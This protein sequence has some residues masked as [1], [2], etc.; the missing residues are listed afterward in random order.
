MKHI[1]ELRV[2]LANNEI[3]VLAINESRL[4]GTISDN[5]V[6]INGYEIVRRER[7]LNGRQR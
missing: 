1:D 5:E 4:D 3:D 7:K 2:F 6:H